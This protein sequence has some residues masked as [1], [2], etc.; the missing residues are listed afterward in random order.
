MYKDRS[1]NCTSPFECSFLTTTGSKTM[2]SS[3]RRPVQY[4][5][6]VPSTTSPL[7]DIF[8]FPLLCA[9]STSRRAHRSQESEAADSR[10][11]NLNFSCRESCFL[12]ALLP[13]LRLYYHLI[14]RGKYLGC[15]C[16]MLCMKLVVYVL[17]EWAPNCF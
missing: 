9:H 3:F 2:Q 11:Q 4:C 5:T 12:F 7:Y 8:G 17:S 6:T 15:D 10:L 16:W 13:L 1:E 14:M